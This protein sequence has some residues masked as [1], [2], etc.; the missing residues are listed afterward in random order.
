[1]YYELY[2]DLFFLENFM[3]DSLLLM[4]VNRVMQYRNS[5]A[6]MILAGAIGSL[7]TCIVVSLPLAR[8]IKFILFGLGINSVMVLFGLGS[9]VVTRKSTKRGKEMAAWFLRTMLVLYAAAVVFGG[10]MYLF[11]PYMKFASLFY[12]AFAGAYYAFLSVW[13]L[14]SCMR[15][16]KQ[17]VLEVT[18]YTSLGIKRVTGFLDTGNELRDFASDDPVNIVDPKLAE[19][20]TL[21][22]EWEKG[23]HMIPYSSI[24]G[25]GVMKVFRI[26]KMCVHMEED[27]WIDNPLLGLSEKT[28]SGSERSEMILNPGIFL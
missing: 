17:T 27:R 8:G 28:L 10:V 14:I 1:M 22:P 15:Q 6:R 13:R 26:E 23:F 20:I 9:E 7:L 18:L 11:R 21:R 12:A 24:G 16:N 5:Y 25:D 3:L 4:A 19:L 2:I